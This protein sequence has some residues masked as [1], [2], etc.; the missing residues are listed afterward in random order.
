MITNLSYKKTR[1]AIII[2][3]VL[4]E[5]FACIF[6]LLPFFLLKDLH[7]A[8]SEIV[9]LS[10]LRPV[11]AFFSFY[12]SEHVTR[13]SVTL[14]NAMIWSGLLSFAGFIP[15]LLTD[16]SFFY[17][18]GATVYMIF[19]RAQIPAWMEVIKTNIS[20][21]KWEKSF[22]LGSIISYSTGVL[23][24]IIFSA[25][26][27]SYTMSWKIPFAFALILASA[28]IFF[29]AA[30]IDNDHTVEKGS[31]GLKEKLYNPIKD[32][33]IL[34]REKREFRHFQWA[35]MIGGLGLMIIQPVIPI[36]FT[37]TLQIKYSNLMTAFCICKALGFVCTTPFWTR[38]LKS[39]SHSGF[40]VMVLVGFALFSFLLIFS[41]ITIECV[42]LSY[43]VYGV[44]QAGSHLIWHLSGPLFSGRES[45]ARYSGVNIVMVGIRGLI[46]PLMGW[47]LM[48]MLSAVSMFV[49]SM[50]LSLAGAAY[51]L[52]ASM[53]K[54][55]YY[56]ITP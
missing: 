28:G 56:S 48:Q 32:S 46:G 20:K 15:A 4:K 8:S 33:L 50:V 1:M 6:P 21:E 2:A 45:S 55:V 36:Y 47:I 13:K 27:D 29:Q 23:Y 16:N 24:T 49:T 3:S 52:Y 43:F 12:F 40:V 39:I 26:M 11:S 34:M 25:M 30:L 7:S 37:T 31:L 17:I 54:E 9:L 38:L 18:F 10:M 41:S 19:T 44:A 53:K 42:F 35:F 22:S 14:K 5:P 51:Y